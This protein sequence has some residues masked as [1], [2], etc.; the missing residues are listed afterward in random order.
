MHGENRTA[1]VLQYEPKPSADVFLA[2]SANL[3]EC[4]CV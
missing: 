2:K 3:A 1:G 4:Q